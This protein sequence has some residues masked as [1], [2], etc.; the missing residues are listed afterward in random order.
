[1]GRDALDEQ[2]DRL[3]RGADDPALLIGTAKDLLEATAKFA[4]EELDV[5][6]NPKADFAEMWFH[7]RDRLGIHP[8]QVAVSLP[9][10][11]VIQTVI[12]SAWKIDGRRQPA[13]QPPR[14]RARPDFAHGRDGRDGLAGGTLGTQADGGGRMCSRDERGMGQR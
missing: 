11:S 3:R 9:G 8:K 14:H 12:E 6:Y 10:G 7:A 13:A 4:L 1:M 5:P 2:L